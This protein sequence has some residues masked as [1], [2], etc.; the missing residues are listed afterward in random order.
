MT[1]RAISIC[2]GVS[3]LC[4]FVQMES[5]RMELQCRNMQELIFIMNCNVICIFI[6][7][8]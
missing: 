3:D 2:K 4:P 6:A 5:L 7:F 1:V 8:Y